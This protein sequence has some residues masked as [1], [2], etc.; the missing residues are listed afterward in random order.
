MSIVSSNP[1]KESIVSF[2]TRLGLR[3]YMDVMEREGIDDVGTL[4]TY[5]Q[6]ELKALGIKVVCAS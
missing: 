6:D 1:D 3:Q 4:Q 5:S 2:L